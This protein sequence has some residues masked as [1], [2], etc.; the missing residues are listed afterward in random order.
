MHENRHIAK[1]NAAIFLIVPALFFYV[2]ELTFSD[3]FTSHHLHS[4]IDDIDLVELGMG[5][6]GVHVDGV[7]IAV[8]PSSAISA[9][10]E[11]I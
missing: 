8:R 11:N 1:T 10:R 2:P 4:A 9:A 6:V 3:L 5:D 7:G